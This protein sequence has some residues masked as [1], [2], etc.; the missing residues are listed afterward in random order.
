[1]VSQFAF[2]KSLNALA[3][4]TFM[5]LPVRAF[6]KYL[7]SLHVIK[8]FPAVRWL[9]NL[10]LCVAKRISHTLEMG[11]ELQKVLICAYNH[12]LSCADSL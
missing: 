6:A 4:K 7:P 2:G 10:P 1:M 9:N 5:S 8:A 11:H 12:R 3:D